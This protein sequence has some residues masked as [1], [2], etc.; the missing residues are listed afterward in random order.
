MDGQEA[1]RQHRAAADAI[2][3]QS[4]PVDVL[5]RV[6]ILERPTDVGRPSQRALALLGRRKRRR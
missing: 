1:N 5:A 2:E 6:E 4:P 3:A